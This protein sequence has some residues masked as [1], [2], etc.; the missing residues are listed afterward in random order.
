[1]KVEIAP[2]VLPGQF[3]PAMRL[4]RALQKNGSKRDERLV[5]LA[6]SHLDPIHREHFISHAI[7]KDE[8]WEL[9]LAHRHDRAYQALTRA[10]LV[11]L[12]T[13]YW[14]LGIIT[15]PGRGYKRRERMCPLVM[16]LMA[17]PL[18]ADPAQ[19][20]FGC[21]ACGHLVHAPLGKTKKCTCPTCKVTFG[22]RF[23]DGRR[24]AFSR[25][26]GSRRSWISS[27]VVSR[28]D[29]YAVLG[30]PVTTPI[31]EMRKAYHRQLMQCHPDL[32]LS[33]G[34]TTALWAAGEATRN[35]NA[36]WN[37]VKQRA[38]A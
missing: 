6:L 26:R 11:A 22:L 15:H 12:R 34:S 14:K 33:L 7:S 10:S 35:L 24:I 20:E 16:E 5:Q 25:P 30:V 19:A 18:G 27:D 23:N 37:L 4:L 1:M 32:V 13:V 31:D 3:L 2:I 21:L 8:L 28:L 9:A 36:A 29:P 17:R 38:R